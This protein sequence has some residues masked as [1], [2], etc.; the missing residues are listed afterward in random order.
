MMFWDGNMGAWGYIL[1][2]LSFVLFWGAIIAAIVVFA[3]SMSG[4]SRRNSGSG[5]SIGGAEELLAERFARG[6]IDES[7]YTARLTALRRAR[8]A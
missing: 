6:E 1:M 2:V 3:R 5:H 7:E 4:S 8:G